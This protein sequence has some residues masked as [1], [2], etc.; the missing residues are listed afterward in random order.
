MT[1][2]QQIKRHEG[3]RLKPYADTVGKLTIGYGHNLSDNGISQKVADKVFWEDYLVAETDA[4]SMFPKSVWDGWDRLNYPR[5][6]VLVNMAFNLGRVRLKRFRRLIQAIK[7]RDYA[8]AGHEMIQSK[9]ARQV[10]NRAA[11]LAKQMVTGRWTK[12]A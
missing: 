7:N 5:K 1:A 3:L 6:A 9:W 12:R 10:P 2:R 8:W 4:R 11:E